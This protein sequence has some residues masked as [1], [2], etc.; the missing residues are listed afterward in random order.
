MNSGSKKQQGIVCYTHREPGHNSLDCPNKSKGQ[1]TEINDNSSNSGKKSIL[2]TSSRT[3]NASWIAMCEGAS[4]VEG[5]VNGTKCQ[6][7]PDTGAE[8]TIVP[9]CLVLE[10]QLTA[11]KVFVKGWKGVPELLHTA[12]IDFEFEG[13]KFQSIVAV[14]H[15]R[16]PCVVGFYIPSQWMATKQLGSFRMSP[17]NLFLG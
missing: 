3:F 11:E 6:I 5:F 8:I 4:H 16:I 15:K 9:G 7:V 14:V 12:H 13:V 1:S 10:H 2:K 17:L